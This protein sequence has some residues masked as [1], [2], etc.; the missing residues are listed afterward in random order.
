[1]DYQVLYGRHEDVSTGLE[2]AK[3]Q[4]QESDSLVIEGLPGMSKN[5]S[6]FPSTAED[7]F[8]KRRKKKYVESP[9]R[10]V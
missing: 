4:G 2:V 5:L 10:S 8:T 1:M 3:S 9:Q 7:N 6:S